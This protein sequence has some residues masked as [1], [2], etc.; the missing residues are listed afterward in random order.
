VLS[1]SMV[2]IVAEIWGCWCCNV[3]WIARLLCERLL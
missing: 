1:D 2:G 3:A